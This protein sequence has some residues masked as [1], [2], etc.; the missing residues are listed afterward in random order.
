MLSIGQ[1]VR[2]QS[3]EEAYTL[4][5]KKSSVVLGGILWLKMQNRTVGTAIDLCDLGLE[6]IE[7]TEEE[8]RIGAMTS[9]RALETHSGLNAYT[10]GAMARCLGSIVG[11]QFRNLATIGGSL[12]GRFGFSDPLTLLMALGAKVE[13]Y[14]RGVLE[15]EEFA[16]LPFERDILVRVILPKTTKGAVYLSQR[17]TATD[18]PVLTFAAARRPEGLVC[19]LGARPGKARL[20]RDEEGIL[21]GGITPES[22][23]T[24]G[25]WLADQAALG[26]DLRAGEE[27]RRRICRVLAR[28]GLLELAKEE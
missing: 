19:A 20:F 13:L 26:H 1:Y 16:A 25:R 17:N 24:F 23:E 11:V 14:H 27:Y 10:G 5:Q 15:L 6:G 28:R 4:C 18:F 2:A 3:L 21:A 12:Y 9:L 22:A 7:E 8:F